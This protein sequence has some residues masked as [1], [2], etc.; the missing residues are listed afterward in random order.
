[1][2]VDKI[3]NNTYKI[4]LTFEDVDKYD[5][6]PEEFV[7]NSEC[8]QK[9]IHEAMEKGDINIDS[10]NMM[11]MRVESQVSKNGVEINISFTQLE[12]NETEKNNK[13]DFNKP[14]EIDSD[15]Y[16]Y[17]ILQ[18]DIMDNV[19]HISKVLNNYIKS[20]KTNKKIK[21]VD[22]ALYKLDNSYYMIFDNCKI[23]QKILPILLEFSTI[24]NGNIFPHLDEVGD[25][26]TDDFI[27]NL[28]Y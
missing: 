23:T 21:K 6:N 12:N 26:I 1:M 13:V 24:K 25:F 14:K 10:V 7:S 8:I 17:Y 11:K 28:S 22:S 2:K 9:I 15:K 27:E 20:N 19:E 3:D 5:M 16:N 18:T 4:Y